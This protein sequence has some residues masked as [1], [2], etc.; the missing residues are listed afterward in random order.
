MKICFAICEY[1]PFHNGHARHLDYIKKT[2]KPDVIAVIMSGSFT[3]RGEIAL[4][5][6]YTRATH[7]IK[8]G[9]DIVFELPVAFSTAPAEIFAKGAISLI[10]PISANKTLCFGTE[11]AEKEKLIS[12]ASALINETKEFKAFYKEEL[13]SGVSS[14]KAKVNALNKMNVENLDFDLLKSPN[15]V[16]AVEYAKAVISSGADIELEPIIRQGAGYNDSDLKKDISSALAVRQAIKDGKL[17]KVK[18]SVPKF[19]YSDLPTALPDVDD[20]IFYSLLKMSKAEMAKILD[21]SEGL[22]NR[23]K[24]LA[25]NC[26]SLGELKEKLKTKRYTY[27]RLSR[28]LTSCLLGIDEK[29]I[30]KYLSQDLYLRVLAINKDKTNLLSTFSKI[31][32]LPLIT[33]K[34]DAD[35]L[36]DAALESLRKDV[37]AN[38][39]FNY[40]ADKKTSDF[41]MKLV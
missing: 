12:T 6:K 35:K 1:N 20:M 26:T 11:S 7:A 27:S 24:A 29:S 34:S 16:L 3:Q 4:L 13:K 31:S 38:D 41:D 5:D 23:I 2:V 37:F 28:I 30:R 8:A 33:R 14:I 39:I 9:A 40:A 18:S 17:R 10:H 22:E 32:R 25:K 36:T 21:C 15:N 19:V